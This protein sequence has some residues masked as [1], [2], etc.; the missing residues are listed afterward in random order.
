MSSAG[1]LLAAGFLVNLRIHGEALGYI[2]ADNVVLAESGEAVTDD[3]GKAVLSDETAT[4]ITGI[5]DEA[6]VDIA[7]AGG[8]V[9]TIEIAAIVK[10]SDVSGI[11]RGAVITRGAEQYFVKEAQTEAVDGSQVLLLSKH[12]H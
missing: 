5:F 10:A 3:N 1:T 12:A 9:G 11:K 7:A 8:E 6:Y 4:S 2:P